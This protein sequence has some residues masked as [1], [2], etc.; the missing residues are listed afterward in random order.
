MMESEVGSILKSQTI[1]FATVTENGVVTKI[2]RSTIQQPKINFKG[3]VIK[4]VDDK[5]QP[6]A[7]RVQ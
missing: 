7:N 1:E 2:G 6:K 5:K 3:G 4:W